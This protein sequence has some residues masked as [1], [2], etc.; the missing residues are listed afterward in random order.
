MD[1]F[2]S[3]IDPIREMLE[4]LD[5]L[6]AKVDAIISTLDVIIETQKVHTEYLEKIL[7][8]LPK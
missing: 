6:K 3:T 8:N 4:E 2:G 5:I 1:E 7:A